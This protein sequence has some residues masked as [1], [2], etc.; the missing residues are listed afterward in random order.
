M[1]RPRS[2]HAARQAEG[3]SHTEQAFKRAP[4]RGRVND[5]GSDFGQTCKEA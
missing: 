1:R 5:P 4:E 2:A 3:V